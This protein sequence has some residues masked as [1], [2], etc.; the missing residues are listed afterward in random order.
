VPGYTGLPGS[1]LDT[2]R[3]HPAMRAATGGVLRYTPAYEAL[4][5]RVRRVGI[6]D[7][8]SLLVPGEYH[9]DTSPLVQMLRRGHH[10]VRLESEAWDRLV[11]W[12]DL[13]APCHG[14]WGEV[15]PIPDG[16]HERRMALRKIVGGPLGDPEAI[17]Q[18][19]HYGAD[20]AG[21]GGRAFPR[22]ADRRES[23]T[24]M[25]GQRLHHEVDGW[26]FGLDDARRRQDALGTTSET[27]D[28][29]GGVAL[30]LAAI[31]GG[32][33]VRGGAVV[34]VA[35]FRIG[36]CEISNEQYARFDAAHDSG[37]YAK[38][39]AVEDDVGLSLNAPRQPVVR[40]SWERALAFCAWLSARTGRRFALPTEAQWEWAARAGSE[41]PLPAAWRDASQ[42]GRFANVADAQFTGSAGGTTRTTG[43]LEH[44][45][46]E[47][48]SPQ[49][50][51]SDDGAVVT[52]SAGSYAP[53]AWGLCD[54]LGNAAEW[55][56]ADGGS[57]SRKAVCGGS[58][59]DPPDRC[60]F[61]CRAEYPAWQRVFN[62]GFRVVCE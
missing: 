60:G 61:A 33:F 15:F 55:A 37:H 26:P 39:H 5:A 49:T 13:N 36:V 44:L 35:S 11:T 14:T 34:E 59:F 45:L 25:D 21:G 42:I 8:V 52:A 17:P 22:A 24:A 1:K 32:R 18:A 3:K 43:G 38:R 62:V 19:E 12:I 31:P 50:V 48:A 27:V 20:P 54:L 2:E 57:G 16:M 6:E 10:D 9:A 40:V 28:V 58:F 30:A 51:L 7:G 56:S 29:G 47:G 53:N 23:S 4:V 46:L 41:G